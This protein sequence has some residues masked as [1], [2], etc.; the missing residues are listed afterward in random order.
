MWFAELWCDKHI[1]PSRF[2]IENTAS[3][4]YN[5]SYFYSLVHLY[6]KWQNMLK[7]K[8]S[9]ATSKFTSGD[10]SIDTNLKML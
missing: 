6:G 7:V 3:K 5:Y 1:A 4:E 10:W 9:K 8:V 2:C